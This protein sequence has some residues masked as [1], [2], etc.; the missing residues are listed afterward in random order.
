[1]GSS[2][3]H[4]QFSTYR[5]LD[6]EGSLQLRIGKDDV[7]IIN[8]EY[9]LTLLGLHEDDLHSEEGLNVKR[10]VLFRRFRCNTQCTH[11]G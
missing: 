8:N 10:D 4:R 2:N 3:F 11:I 5:R 7:L 1:M 6:K 9:T